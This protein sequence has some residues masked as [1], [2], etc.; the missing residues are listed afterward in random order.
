MFFGNIERE[1]LWKEMLLSWQSTQLPGN[2]QLQID[3]GQGKQDIW[4]CQC[5]EIQEVVKKKSM[6]NLKEKAF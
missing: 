1:L 4:D 3:K 6:K 5:E 2:L